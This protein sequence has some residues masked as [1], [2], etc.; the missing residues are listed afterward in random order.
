[1]NKIQLMVG[2]VAWL[3]L[4]FAASFIG[5]LAAFNAPE[6]Y[7][8]MTQPE[9]APPAWLFGPVWTTLY[10]MMAV[11]AW[12]VWQR[13]GFN[14]NRLA[15]GV[16]LLQ[17]ALNALWSWLFFAWLQGAWSVL[18]IG[19]LWVMIAVTIVLFW[20]VNRWA[21]ML[22]IPYLVWVSFATALNTAMWQLNPNILG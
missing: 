1:M 10:A 2:L 15:L 4:C 19:L 13:G 7:G 22:L 6:I 14:Q 5:A 9:W 11:A 21:G 12:L 18:N 17:L 8:Q 20:R 3:L 16:F